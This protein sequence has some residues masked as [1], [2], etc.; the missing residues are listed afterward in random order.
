VPA[1]QVNE[2]LEEVVERICMVGGSATHSFD[3]PVLT[4]RDETKR[5]GGRERIPR[6]SAG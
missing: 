4:I 5:D 6:N 2:I 1:E 3:P